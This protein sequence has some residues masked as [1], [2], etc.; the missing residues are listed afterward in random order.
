MKKSM[1]IIMNILSRLKKI[2]SSIIGNNSEFCG[3]EKEYRAFILLPN[4][5][6]EP[7]REPS[8]DYAG[9]EFCETCG[10]RNLKPIE[11]TFTITTRV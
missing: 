5:G 8:E 7:I 11:A 1:A 3:C 6:G 10:K 2:E 9:A 4:P